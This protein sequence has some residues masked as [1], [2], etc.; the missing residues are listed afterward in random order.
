MTPEKFRDKLFVSVARKD[1]LIDVRVGITLKAVVKIDDESKIEE[2][3]ELAKNDLIQGVYGGRREEL[4]V[5][6][7]EV[8]SGYGVY[9]SNPQA[10]DKL[11]KFQETL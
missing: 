5:L 7:N 6:L 1:G 4:R 3:T 8:I 2:A 10:W 9:E 11:A